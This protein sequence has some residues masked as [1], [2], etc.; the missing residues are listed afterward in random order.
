MKTP[1]RVASIV[2]TRN[3]I[4]DTDECLRTLLALD[5]AAHQVFLVDNGSDDASLAELRRGW[6]EK[7]TFLETG[8]NLGAAAGWNAGLRA[9]LAAGSDYFLVLNNDIAV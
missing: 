2:L 4:A 3:N 7:L 1:P 9:A 5:Y 6:A 8:R